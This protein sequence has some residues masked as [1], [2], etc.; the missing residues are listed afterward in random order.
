MQIFFSRARLYTLLG[1]LCLANASQGLAQTQPPAAGELQDP[2]T[3]YVAD[4][5]DEVMDTEG[6][7]DDIE[8]GTGW[9]ARGD[10]RSLFDHV[11]EDARDGSS[12][13]DSAVIGRLRWEGTWTFTPALRASARLAGSCTDDDCDLDFTM[14]H[15]ISGTTLERG[16]IT[17][18]ELFLHFF[19]SERFDVAFRRLQTKLVM[20]AG[21]FAKSLDRAD[22]LNA[23]ITWT[24][25]LHATLRHR[26]GWEGQ[27]ILQ[28]N[29]SHGAGN[30]RRSPL[31]FSSSSSRVTTVAA[32]E[33]LEPWGPVVQRGFDVNYLPSSLLKDGNVAGRLEDYWGFVGRFAAEWPVGAGES[34]L[35]IAGAAGYAPETPTREALGLGGSGD[36]GGFAWQ[37]AASVMDFLPGHD[38]GV[39]Y[40]RADPGWLLSPVFV[41]NEVQY[42]VRYRWKATRAASIDLRVRRRQE[43]EPLVSA[44]R[45]RDRYDMFLRATWRISPGNR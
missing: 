21:L 13:D 11:D 33:N 35:R 27:L 23:N 10:L 16:K 30:V 40:G 5:A 32:L 12:A 19:R 14:D 42:E 44:V 24:D 7:I 28:H 31:D 41:N 15:E 1:Y 18:D 8:P 2:E 3:T 34:R 43:L 29:S 9:S 39:N 4:S 20:R 22:S 26:N 17:F 6:S 38:L 45:K 36:A 37:A 25:G